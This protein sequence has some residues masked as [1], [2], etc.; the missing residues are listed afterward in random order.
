MSKASTKGSISLPFSAKARKQSKHKKRTKSSKSVH[1]RKKRSRKGSKRKLARNV[2][3]LI[4]IVLLLIIITA[5]GYSAYT[6]VKKIFEIRDSRQT[7]DIDL[8]NEVIGINGIPVYPGSEF[9]FENVLDN[10]TVQKTLTDGISAYRLPPLDDIDDAYAF[11]KLYLPTLNWTLLNEVPLNSP[12]MIYG[13]YWSN[14]NTA[15]RIYSRIN[16]IWYE[17][18]SIDEAKSGLS[19]RKLETIKRE[20]IIKADETQQLLPGFDW[21]LEVPGEYILDYN[22]TEFENVIGVTFK[23]NVTK[24]KIIFTPIGVT[25]ETPED[26][27]LENFLKKYNEDMGLNI[28][29][30]NTKY[31]RK[32]NKDMLQVDLT[33]GTTAYVLQNNLDGH[34]YIVYSNEKNDDFVDYIIKNV[35]DKSTI[36]LDP[37][38]KLFD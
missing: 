19:E 9:I 5:L 17:T 33:E 38:L 28:E 34:S 4:R 30:I 3:T 21:A 13:Q 20:E 15:V 6:A 2:P 11:Y 22:S 12:D 1:N 25:L 32:Y 10:E 18:I 27:M 37:K 31:I 24:L 16:D 14:G 7:S 35:V 8:T 23:H 26:I 29:V 36:K